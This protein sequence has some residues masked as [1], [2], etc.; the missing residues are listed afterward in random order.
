MEMEKPTLKRRLFT[1]P[2]NSRYFCQFQTHFFDRKAL[3][4]YLLPTLFFPS[5]Q[6]KGTRELHASLGPTFTPG[7]LCGL[8]WLW[9]DPRVTLR[10][11]HPPF[12]PCRLP[13]HLSCLHH[14][15]QAKVA[16]RQLNPL[17]GISCVR[18]SI[19][20]GTRPISPRQT[21]FAY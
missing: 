10:T 4:F 9:Q 11:H 20:S 18:Q 12:Y 21:L 5:P 17:L 16:V 3:S 2:L 14:I 8:L 13:A 7:C 6:R 19:R 1:S 15:P